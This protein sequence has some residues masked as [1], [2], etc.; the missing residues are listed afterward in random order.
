[1]PFLDAA[2]KLWS[3]KGT[4]AVFCYNHHAMTVATF[5]LYRNTTAF[6]E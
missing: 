1:M 6:V 2:Q 4:C 3:S 5:A